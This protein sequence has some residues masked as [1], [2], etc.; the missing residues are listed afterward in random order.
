PR[1][2]NTDDTEVPLDPD[3]EED[4]RVDDEITAADLLAPTENLLVDRF[5]K[6]VIMPFADE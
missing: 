5:G 1:R 2:V 3:P 4:T 6:P